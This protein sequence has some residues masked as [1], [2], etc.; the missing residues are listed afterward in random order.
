MKLKSNKS[1]KS[2]LDLFL[3]WF[4]LV[5]KKEKVPDHNR[6]KRGNVDNDAI[7][8]RLSAQGWMLLELPIRKN[9][10]ITKTCV[11]SRWK[12]VASKGEKSIEV[13]GTTIDEALRNIG[14]TLGVVNQNN[15]K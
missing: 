15:M 10:P 6:L 12:V 14:I 1:K 3:H 13:G 7:R 5:D 2:F 11:V 8:A 4:H 9:D